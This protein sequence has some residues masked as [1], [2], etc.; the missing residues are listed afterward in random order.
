VSRRMLVIA[1]AAV[2]A[3]LPGAASGQ[4]AQPT[5]RA[6][7]GP[8][9]TISFT[10]V[11]GTPVTH[12][13][14]GEYTIAVLDRATEHNFHLFGQGVEQATSVEATETTTWTVTFLNG[15]IYRYQC[16]PHASS[17]KGQFG[18]GNV[19]AA[20]KPPAKLTGRVGPGKTISLKTAAGARV[21][22]LAPAKYQLTIRDLTKTEN[23]HL[24]GPGVNRKTKVA[25]KG[26]ATWTLAL[27]AGKHSYRSDRTRALRGSFT[28]G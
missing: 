8:G 25:G 16:D 20:P 1:L 23:F 18:V 5:L 11:D 22:R 21:K 24:V 4:Q 2:S 12:L 14:P 19:P 26:T 3:A 15:R 10:R 27:K 13:D 7:V 17:L 28:V 9:F 6:Q